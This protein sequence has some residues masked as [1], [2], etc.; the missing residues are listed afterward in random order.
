MK[1]AMPRSNKMKI[2]PLA[3]ETIGA[4]LGNFPAVVAGGGDFGI[5]AFP[6]TT[7]ADRYL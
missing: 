1:R 2:R 7:S 4:Q 3:I 5:S 6:A